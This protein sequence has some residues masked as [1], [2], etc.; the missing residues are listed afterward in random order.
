MN[1]LRTLE[2]YFL[3][4]P[5]FSFSPQYVEDLPGYNGLRVH[6][7]DEG[8]VDAEAVWLGLH[9]EPTWCYLYRK[10]IPVFLRAGQRVV[11]PDLISPGWGGIP[12]ERRDQVSKRLFAHRVNMAQTTWGV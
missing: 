8:P 12:L 3:N 6:F 4:W 7:I 2:E 9:G 5:G 1:I 10:M 11:A